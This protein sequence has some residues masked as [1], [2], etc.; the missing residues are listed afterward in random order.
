MRLM[1]DFINRKILAIINKPRIKQSQSK[2]I[3]LKWNKF[4]PKFESYMKGD[5]NVKEACD[6]EN[7]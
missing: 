2:E 7:P 3:N 5:A 6:M 1:N 4:C